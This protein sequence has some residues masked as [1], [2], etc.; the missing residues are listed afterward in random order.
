MVGK[1][2]FSYQS[3]MKKVGFELDLTFSRFF[4]RRP[5]YVPSISNY[6]NTRLVGKHQESNQDGAWSAC[7]YISLC[8]N[9]KASETYQRSRAPVL[10]GHRVLEFRKAMTPQ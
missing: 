8:S 7:P 3:F 5:L 10:Q 4:F 1:F 6:E 2:T 9:H